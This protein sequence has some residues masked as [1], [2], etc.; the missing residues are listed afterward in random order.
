MKSIGIIGLG[1]IGIPLSKNLIEKGFH[2]IG[3]G[4]ANTPKKEIP[5]EVE[6]EQLQLQGDYDPFHSFEQCETL[7]ITI[8]PSAPHYIE[9]LKKWVDHFSDKHIILLSSTGVYGNVGRNITENSDTAPQRESAKKIV[10]LEQY[11]QKKTL[12]HTLI[13]LAGLVGPKRNPAR[14]FKRTLT[15]PS[16]QSTVNLVHQSDA[17]SAI[18]FIVEQQQPPKLVNVAAP[19]HPTKG[20]FYTKIALETGYP[21]PNVDSSKGE[22]RIIHTTFLDK[23]GFKFNVTNFYDQSLYP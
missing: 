20:E 2:V 15:V 7:I 6:Y 18:S 12:S 11:I 21:A 3:T 16:P 14:F 13:R 1:W 10:E 9:S 19:F 17:V 23:G 22:K 4:T 8:P 5:E